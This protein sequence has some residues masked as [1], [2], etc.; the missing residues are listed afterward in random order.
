MRQLLKPRRCRSRAWASQALVSYQWTEEGSEGPWLSDDMLATIPEVMVRK[1]FVT[2]RKR[3]EPLESPE[4]SAR[5]DAV[6]E[7]KPRKE[8]A[9]DIFSLVLED[10]PEPGPTTPHHKQPPR[11]VLGSRTIPEKEAKKEG[12]QEPGSPRSAERSRTSRELPA[13]LPLQVGAPTMTGKERAQPELRPGEGR[14]RVSTPHIQLPAKPPPRREGTKRRVEVLDLTGDAEPRREPRQVQKARPREGR[15]ERRQWSG[16]PS[17]S[18]SS[19]S[20]WRRSDYY[21]RRPQYDR[22]REREPWD[23]RRRSRK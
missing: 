2:K 17:S 4:S 6:P 22:R 3:K 12:P 7:K 15:E 19:S 10:T 11:L 1:R 23:G 20:G 14:D 13:Q 9:T 5:V 21:K 16:H 18:S 8:E